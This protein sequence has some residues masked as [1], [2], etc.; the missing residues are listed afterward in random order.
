MDN[1]GQ[2]WTVSVPDRS[3]VHESG[4]RLTFDGHPNSSSFSFTPSARPEGITTL[5]W[6]SMIRLGVEA[7]R[8]A[9]A[10]E[11]DGSVPV[12]RKP[13]TKPVI[14]KRKRR[15]LPKDGTPS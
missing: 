5:Q 1:E 9:F 8:N 11:D 7:Y 13:A 2:G 14:I 15:L 3:A 10:E 12:A 4:V 6:V